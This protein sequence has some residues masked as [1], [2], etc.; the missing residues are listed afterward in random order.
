MSQT[1][2]AREGAIEDIKNL[3][4]QYDGF[5]RVYVMTRWVSPPG[6]TRYLAVFLFD[7]AN[8]QL[9]EIT[10]PAAKATRHKLSNRERGYSLIYHGLGFDAHH[11]ITKDLSDALGVQLTYQSIL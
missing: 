10:A 2:R 5:C 3:I 7:A 1:D 8:R 11:A 9:V 4:A 6:T